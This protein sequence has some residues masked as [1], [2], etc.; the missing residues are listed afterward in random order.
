MTWC[1]IFVTPK[2]PL[3]EFKKE[4]TSGDVVPW[5]VPGPMTGNELFLCAV[6]SERA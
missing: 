4:S 5:L 2:M 3:H 1:G 6:F